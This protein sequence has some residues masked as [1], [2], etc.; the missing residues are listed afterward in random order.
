MRNTQS[1][2]LGALLAL[3]F[4]PALHAQTAS[5]APT[6]ANSTTASQAPTGQAPDEATRKIT[7]LVHAGK[8]AEAQQLTAG[9]LM[10][11][12]DDQR[13]IKAKALIDKLLVPASPA[14]ATQGSNPPANNVPVAEAAA[15]TSAEHFTGMER[16]DYNALI[17]LGRQAQQT[18]DLE[19]QKASL[20]QFMD[21]SAVFLQKHPAEMLLWQLRVA[22]ALSL[23]DPLT[24]YEAGQR[25][26]TAGAA[27]SNDPTLQRLLAQLKNKGWL[28]KQKVDEAVKQA[29]TDWLVGAWDVHFSSTD[30]RGRLVPPSV[31]WSVDLIKSGSSIEAS[32]ATSEGGR[33]SIFKATL[34]DS[35]ISR[36]ELPDS[37][38]LSCESDRTKSAITIVFQMHKHKGQGDL[39]ETFVYKMHK[40]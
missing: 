5:S 30:K 18:T 6:D 27:D 9:L 39:G 29:K 35:G 3:I 14:T 2:I 25:L 13:L 20:K 36:C 11:Y 32:T 4:L 23:N 1:F 40:K 31:D 17:E 26:L 7:E 19:Q 15:D 24:G 12:P 38:V 22:S 16:I 33:L 34:L 10:A 21:E 28:D 8:Y 37:D